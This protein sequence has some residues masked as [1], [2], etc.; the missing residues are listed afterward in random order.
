MI[1]LAALATL[2]AAHAVSADTFVATD[3]IGRDSV[4]G[5]SLTDVVPDGAGDSALRLDVYGHYA[6]ASG[7]GG[8]G[9]LWLAY[10]AGAG[11]AFGLGNLDVGGFYT[12]AASPSLELVGRLGLALPTGRDG[13]AFVTTL[14]LADSY[15][16]RPGMT[17]A[18][19]SGSLVYRGPV[20]ARI[21]VGADTLVRAPPERTVALHGTGAVGVT[22]AADTTV[23]AELTGLWLAG[24][25]APGSG[26][27]AGLS[28]HYALGDWRPYAAVMLPI[29][30]ASRAAYVVTAILGL[31]AA[32]H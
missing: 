20:I 11:P 21:E 4:A 6:T 29:D 23:T 25:S 22:V 32:L 8:Y 27:A 5:A 15:A 9:Q 14:R 7:F 24:S 2:I 13:G 28:M 18:R 10:A 3:R 12:A 17:I 30:H 1:R 16:L 26:A 19:M 31:D